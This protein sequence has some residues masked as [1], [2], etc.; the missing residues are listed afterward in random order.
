[1]VDGAK[2]EGCQLFGR[3]LTNAAEHDGAS[4]EHD[5]A[6]EVL[7]DVRIAIHDGL[8]NGVLDAT[9]FLTKAVE[10]LA[11]NCD[12]VSIWEL[13]GLLL[14]RTLAR[15]RHLGVKV[16]SNVDQ[17]LLQMQIFSTSSQLVTMPYTIPVEDI[18]IFMWMEGAIAVNSLVV[19]SQMPANMVLPPE[20]M[21]LL[22]RYLRMST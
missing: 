20:S 1:M 21:T 8:E 22:Y 15:L 17:L 11:C 5:V 16:Q 6:V 3:A 9:R 14:V 4:H 2:G 10:A 19:R 13:T 7:K 18:L 12:D